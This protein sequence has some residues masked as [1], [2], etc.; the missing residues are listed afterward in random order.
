[1][2]NITMID[3]WE[4]GQKERT[5][6]YL[7]EGEKL[8]LV[9]T[10]PGPSGEKILSVLKEKGYHK[11]DLKYIVVTHIHLDHAGAAGFLLNKCPDA[12]LLVHPKGAQHMADPT[13]LIAGARAAFD[14]FD[15]LFHPV[16]PAPWERII[17]IEDKSTL[18][19]G[20]RQLT[21]YHGRGH[22]DHHL[23]IMD[24]MS[25]GLFS[26][27]LLGIYS[28]EF[29]EYGIEYSLLSSAPNQFNPQAFTESLED[30]RSLN[31]HTIYFT[32]FG[33]K[34]GLTDHYLDLCLS[35]LEI[36]CQITED[37]CAKGD[38]TWQEIAEP[39]KGTVKE[40]LIKMGW[41]KEKPLPAFI[42]SNIDLNAKGLLHW[43]A[44]K[45]CCG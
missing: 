8:T 3:L 7:I 28:P 26:G 34:T 4:G 18:D 43:W 15:S 13:R 40:I 30:I 38:S 21:F 45:H 44:K 19:L 23:T 2:N 25:R 16:I 11:S 41:P 12:K 6:G 9:E 24:S 22:A 35:N 33:A 36:Y 20:E 1:M 39:L 42:A 5:C 37:V 14:N 17:S 31:P 27:D 32:H 29:A 10:G